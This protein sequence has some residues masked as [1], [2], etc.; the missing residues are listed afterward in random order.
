MAKGI[1][2]KRIG[3]SIPLPG[4][5]PYSCALC[6]ERCKPGEAVRWGPRRAKAAHDECARRLD[7][8][9]VERAPRP[10]K[11]EA[12][13][14]LTLE[15]WRHEHELHHRALLLWA[16]QHPS[17]RN[18]RAVARAVAK[19]EGS[20]RKWSSTNRWN[21]RAEGPMADADA[22]RLYRQLYL[23]EHGPTE[24]PEVQPFVVVPLGAPK[25]EEIPLG[26]A[27]ADV[28]AA[29]RLVREQI[30]QKRKHDDDIRKKHVQLVDAGLGYVVKELQDGKIRAT[31]RDI[32]TLLA[33]RALLTGEAGSNPAGG[34]IA[35]ESVRVRIAR[36]RG[37]DLLDALDEDLEEL[38][39]IVGALK[40]RRDAAA[41]SSPA[42]AAAGD[43]VPHLRV[44]EDD[45]LE[46][47]D[48]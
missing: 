36:E 43:A 41:A 32:P 39:V 30:L 10:P 45:V 35:A 7:P 33:A 4:R 24:L 19:S 34:I 28:A 1:D 12:R 22:V 9:A 21:D 26:E 37:T 16:M 8:A 48:G 31:L 27:E 44:V 40:G 38:R 6:G 18:Q 25:A 29:D 2:W 47:T 46:E 13:G 11:A 42:R 5:E 15:R 14:P 23:A 20:V 3:A 17:K